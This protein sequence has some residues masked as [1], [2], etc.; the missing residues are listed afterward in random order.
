[1]SA[2]RLTIFAKASGRFEVRWDNPP[3]SL[4]RKMQKG[5]VLDANRP[6]VIRAGSE[7]ELEQ[8]LKEVIRIKHQQGHMVW[9]ANNVT[10][11]YIMYGPTTGAGAPK[12]V[13]N[14]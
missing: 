5:D 4:V 11:R 3:G 2:V 6:V 8:M 14:A 9:V 13:G 1:M 10:G 12:L 7:A